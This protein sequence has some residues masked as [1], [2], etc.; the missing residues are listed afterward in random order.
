MGISSFQ[1][2]HSM[3]SQSLLLLL[4]VVFSALLLL[5][6]STKQK[7]KSVASRR[8]PPGP[9]K[10]PLI[11][12]LHQLGSLPHVGLQRLSN[13]YGPLM[14]LKLGSVPT[15]VVSSADMAREIFREHDLVFSSRPESYAGKKLSYGCNDVVFAPYG[16]YWREVRKIVILE[17]LSAKRVQSFQE[18]REEEVTLMLDAITHSSGPVNLSELTFFLSNNVI[19]RVTFGKK[20]DG[21]G[22]DGTGRF[23][24]ILQ[25]TQNLLGAFCIADFFPWMGWFNKLNGLDARLEKNFLEL[26]KI[27]EKVIEEHLD[28]ERPEPEHEDLVDVL[29][30]V[31]KDPKRAVA[32]SI[33]K[34]KG[35]LTDMFVAGTDTSSASL[36]WTMAELIRNPSVMRKAQE[37]VRSAVRGKY[38]VEESD[39][40]RLIYLKLVVKESLR[41]HPPAPLLVPRKTNEDCTIRGYEV[42]AN[43]QVFVNGKSIATD[44][45][46][47]EN[48]NE[49]QP[50][51]FLDS[52]IDFRG[53]N[54]E[55]LPFGAGRRGCPGTNFA[56]LLIELALANL[57]HRLTGNWLMG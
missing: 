3:V 49:F 45:N 51:R 50:E 16:E 6:L 7:M 17:L 53:Q 36:V 5:L 48:P 14:Y 43:T 31:Q 37:E 29:I 25:E 20:F 13:E 8:L 46:Y 34:I 30:R 42:P 15:L 40:S 55:L 27:Y 1:A 26:D 19:C 35:V 28:P 23:P 9:K 57:L 22:D 44:P 24:G 21:G 32:L 11:G 39:I 2:S 47:W 4:L 18:L 56:V 41:L 12:N 10:L 33:E 54:F 52:S 38:Q